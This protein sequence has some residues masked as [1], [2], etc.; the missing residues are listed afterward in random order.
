VPSAPT[1]LRRV[2]YGVAWDAP[3]TDGGLPITCYYVQQSAGQEF[4]YKMREYRTDDVNTRRWIDP[5]YMFSLLRNAMLIG[6]GYYR[7]CAANSIG[8]GPWSEVFWR[9]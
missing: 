2:A 9:G 4:T 1:G 3:E 7:V 8:R 5:L 6:M